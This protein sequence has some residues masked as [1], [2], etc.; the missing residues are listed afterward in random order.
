MISEC[1]C[2]IFKHF[3]FGILPDSDGS[4]I[5][6]FPLGFSI[7]LSLQRKD[8]CAGIRLATVRNMVIKLEAVGF[9]HKKVGL[10]RS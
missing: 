2:F 3:C 5:C 4:G 8:G 1:R 7:V 10:Y 9:L 6:A